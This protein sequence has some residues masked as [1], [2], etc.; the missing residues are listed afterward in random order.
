MR[1]FLHVLYTSVLTSAVLCLAAATVGAARAAS[2]PSGTEIHVRL[3]NQ[4]DT[5]QTNSGQTFSATVTEPVVVSGRTLLARG[6]RVNGR[7]VEAVGS[8]RLKRPA[9]ITLE[10]TQV[11]GSSISTE[12]LRIDAKSHLLRNVGII[13]GETAAGAIIGSAADGKKGAAVGAA[14]GAGAGTATAYMTGKKEIVLPVETA[15]TFVVAGS[16]AEGGRERGEAAE[17]PYFSDRDRRLIR[18]FFA[19][20]TENLPPGLAKRGG[21]L[22]PGLE[23]HIERN[24]TLPPGLEKRLEPFPEDLNRQLPRL[25]SGHV[26]V[27][28]GNRALAL[29]PSN[30]IL[31]LMYLRQGE[32]EQGEDEDRDRDK[33]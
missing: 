8:G 12:P 3:Q 22:P 31:D 1:N 23:K 33:D 16:S 32:D 27:I 10:L 24:G 11:A 5:G 17:A 28:L 7:V 9:S 14:I 15:L 13:G 2:I 21:H 18:H 20:N 19:I 30:R 6:A 25:P 4:L 29:D 26:R